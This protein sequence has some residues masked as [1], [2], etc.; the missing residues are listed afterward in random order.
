MPKPRFLWVFWQDSAQK[1]TVI[2]RF[3]VADAP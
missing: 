3:F 2:A 1:T